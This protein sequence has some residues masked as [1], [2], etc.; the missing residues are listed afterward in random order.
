MEANLYKV[1]KGTGTGKG[2]DRDLYVALYSPIDKNIILSLNADDPS[3]LS[4]Y[5]AN[6]FH[7]KLR[8]RLD[9]SSGFIP[10]FDFNPP[11]PRINP[12]GSR[13]IS[14]Q[15]ELSQDEMEH[16]LKSYNHWW[17]DLQRNERKSAA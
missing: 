3:T 8:G 14:D 6:D 2:E 5:V 13:F 1:F 9:Q 11:F 15:S 7:E 17:Y 16:F 12:S 4:G 10:V